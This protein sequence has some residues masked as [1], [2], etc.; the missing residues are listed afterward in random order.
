MS[1]ELTDTVKLNIP[2]HAWEKAKVLLYAIRCVIRKGGGT[3][4]MTKSQNLVTLRVTGPADMV[5]S[6]IENAHK[7][8]RRIAQVED[9]AREKFKR[10]F[11]RTATSRREE[12]LNAVLDNAYDIM[13]GRKK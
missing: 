4:R 9:N 5:L 10:D 13:R 8:N 7:L 12:N 3:S 11:V 2:D 6:V 1:D